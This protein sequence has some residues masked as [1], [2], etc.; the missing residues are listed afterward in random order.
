MKISYTWLFDH[1]QAKPSD[2]PIDSLVARFNQSTAE[3]EHVEK[4]S[5]DLTNLALAQVTAINNTTI[6]V[7]VPEWKQEAV[8]PARAVTIGEWYII[9]RYEDGHI[10]ASGYHFSSGKEGLLPTFYCTES[11]K[12]GAWRSRIQ[13]TDYII[14]VD[15]KSITNRPDLWGHRG[16]A[17]EVAALFNVAMIEESSF[18]AP[19]TIQ[20]VANDFIKTSA[21]HRIA[22]MQTTITQPSSAS[23]LT[24]ASRLLRVD[25]KPINNIVDITN[26]VM[27]DW[28]QPMHA[29]DAT[30]IDG[31]LSARN[32]TNDESLQLLDGTEIK[33]THDDI[34]IADNRKPLSLAGVMGGSASSI[35]HSTKEV[36]L[37]AA[38]FDAGT[39]RRTAARHKKRTDSSARFE[40]SLDPFAVT[41][42]IARFISIA[43]KESISCD[44]TIM[45]TSGTLPKSTIIR[46]EHRRIEQKIGISLS[47]ETIIDILTKL[48]FIVTKEG[49]S[50]LITVPT[51]RATKDITQ[52][53]DIVEEIARIIGY[54]T[55][56]PQ[57]P[58][59]VTEPFSLK[60]I[61]RKR[62]IKS[63]CA[64][65]LNMKEIKQYAFFDESFNQSINY[66][67]PASAY[68]ESPVSANWKHLITTLVPH[69]LHAVKENHIDHNSLAFFSTDRIWQLST[70][71]V[72]SEKKSL[73]GIVWNKEKP[74]DFYVQKRL[75]D[76]IF[77]A[78]GMSVTYEQAHD[79][80]DPW[81]MPYQTAH[82]LH[83]NQKI[84]IMGLV[85]TQMLSLCAP[86]FGW[87]FELNGDIL[88]QY[89]A[90]IHRYVASSKYPV[91]TRDISMLISTAYKTAHVEEII[92]TIDT[93]IIEVTLIDFFEKPEWNNQKSMT[94]RFVISDPHKTLTKPEADEIWDRVAQALIKEGA[95]IR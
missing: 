55:I 50:Y 54:N 82:I 11:D 21:C 69:L 80:I 52:Q 57:G 59:R 84:G 45:Q 91:M 64:Y 12:V 28:G 78:I 13:T 93:R 36:I 26:Y 9:A 1:L 19:L 53:E 17:R 70:S 32:A 95:V 92:R 39:I 31:S 81:Y 41:Q 25:C 75:L 40:K 8:L 16:F 14:E 33:L 3:I 22:L 2:I 79:T 85:P 29:F 68:V 89:Q 48:T 67:P 66:T 76:M 87:I 43:Q 44:T 88:S 60:D 94:Y 86:G 35:T 61:E 58:T 5:I 6:R 62:L 63:L 10:W 20:E 65:H 56:K 71:G 83:N 30:K 90:S 47:S 42:A 37:E 74:I 72:L 38:C 24:L 27:L 7:S 46:I 49:T 51:F 15:N 73:A 23:S 34:V 18:L 77:H 4:I